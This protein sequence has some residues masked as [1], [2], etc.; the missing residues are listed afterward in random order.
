M[1]QTAAEGIGMLPG[2]FCQSSFEK[3][4]GLGS[5]GTWH[6]NIASMACMDG[7]LC[8]WHEHTTPTLQPGVLICVHACVHGHLTV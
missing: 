1:V 2:V 8:A 3:H 7:S 6:G 4:P 5:A